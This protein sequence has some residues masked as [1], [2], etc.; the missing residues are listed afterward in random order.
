MR[1]IIVPADG[2]VVVNGEARGPFDLSNIPSNVHAVQWYETWGEVELADPT[3]AHVRSNVRI[4][5][6]SPYLSAVEAWGSWRAPTNNNVTDIPVA[7][8]K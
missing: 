3:N 7:V 4:D 8:V 6:L 2:V 1:V 5:D